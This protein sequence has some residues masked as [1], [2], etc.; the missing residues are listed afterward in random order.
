MSNQIDRIVS[1]SDRAAMEIY[2]SLT[3]EHREMVNA[4]LQ[5]LL[6]S[7]CTPVPCVFPP[8]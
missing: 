5:E 7:P 1:D 2:W 4:Y 3:P 8:R 6:T